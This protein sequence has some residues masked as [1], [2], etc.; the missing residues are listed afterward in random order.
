VYP[1]HQHRW[2]LNTFDKTFTFNIANVNDETPSDI[3]LT[4][5]LIIVGNTAANTDLGTN[6]N[7]K[8]F[9]SFIIYSFSEF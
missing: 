9:G 4:G 6:R 1:P 7:T 8:V 5:S 2:H 3:T